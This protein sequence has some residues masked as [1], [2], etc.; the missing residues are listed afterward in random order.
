MDASHSPGH[1]STVGL[2]A[3]VFIRKEWRSTWTVRFREAGMLTAEQERKSR[4]PG[5]QPWTLRLPALIRRV[6][7]TE[8]HLGKP[9]SQRSESQIP[10]LIC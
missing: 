1:V 10:S 2:L 5:L 4:C 6:S 8:V 7:D 9:L 3:A